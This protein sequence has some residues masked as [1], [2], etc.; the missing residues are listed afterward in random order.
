MDSRKAFPND[1]LLGRVVDDR[2]ILVGI[3]GQ[4]ASSRVYLALSTEGDA[5]VALKVLHEDV[6]RH[7]RVVE[8]FRR[9]A[10]TLRKVKDPRIVRFIAEGTIAQ[11][12]HNH[13]TSR[14]YRAEFAV[15]STL[16]DILATREPMSWGRI[17]RLTIELLGALE[18]AHSIGVI[19]R[20]IKPAN[21][22][23]QS[24]AN[25]VE[26]VK[27][28]DFG[29]AKLAWCG[30]SGDDDGTFDDLTMAGHIIGTPRY[31]APEQFMG[32]TIDGRADLYAVGAI[33]YEMVFEQKYRGQGLALV[34]QSMPE[35]DDDSL[36]DGFPFGLVNVLKKALSTA[37]SDRFRDA[38]TFSEALLTLGESVVTSAA[39]MTENCTETPL[40]E[41]LS[42]ADQ[43]KSYSELYRTN[44][45]VDGGLFIGREIEMARIKELFSNGSRAV[46]L[47]GIGGVGKTSLCLNYGRRWLS[48][49]SGECWHIDVAG[50]KTTRML[51]DR[52]LGILGV[53]GLP[54]DEQA[55]AELIRRRG[56]ML[57]ILDEAEMQL[58]VVGGFVD[59]L[60]EQCEAVSVL[61]S[62]RIR[63]K[64]ERVAPCALGPLALMDAVRLSFALSSEF[65]ADQTISVAD[66]KKFTKKVRA[67]GCL[68]LAIELSSSHGRAVT[69]HAVQMVPRDVDETR[70]DVDDAMDR[71][72]RWSWDRL[73]PVEQ[74]LLNTLCCFKHSFDAEATQ[75]VVSSITR[76]GRLAWLMHWRTLSKKG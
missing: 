75:A 26:D 65:Q 46:C 15:G 73:N 53:P 56:Q 25:G 21:V 71:T 66:Q 4:G 42:Q 22:I 57:L 50:C 3:L 24:Y 51:I 61:I 32:H 63:L 44:V 8:R 40:R 70:L 20:D 52:V 39:D 5:R 14:A 38:D 19:H 18:A 17:K 37:A 29:V 31:M 48:S 7:R 9:E 33:L 1:R 64:H 69:E 62:S 34:P 12:A 6:L 58:D 76:L 47:Y 30:F 54:G 72:L 74:R 35:L 60:V 16:K 59:M 68:P 28:L 2:F 36:R 10:A 67:L 11:S 27:L 23:V 55:V 45:K 43:S 41:S 49:E 13:A